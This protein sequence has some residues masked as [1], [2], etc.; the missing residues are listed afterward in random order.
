M[1]RAASGLSMRPVWRLAAA[2]THRSAAFVIECAATNATLAASANSAAAAALL[3][4]AAAASRHAALRRSP[5]RSER[6]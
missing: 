6:P 1:S 2:V 3:P 5:R 4:P